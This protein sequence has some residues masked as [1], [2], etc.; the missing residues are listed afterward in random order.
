MVGMEFDWV[1]LG[2]GLCAGKGKGNVKPLSSEWLF[3]AKGLV[4]G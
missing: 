1:R 3:V 2:D 4:F